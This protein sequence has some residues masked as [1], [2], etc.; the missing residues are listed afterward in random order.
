M[1]H[2]KT[3]INITP[4]DQAAKDILIA[5]LSQIGF[6]SFMETE[7]GIEAY[8]PSDKD[9][10][11]NE[12]TVPF[13]AWPEYTF[14]IRTETIEDK[15]WNEEWEKNYFKPIVIGNQCLVRS[16]FQKT[17]LTARY[18]ILID[19]RMAFGTGYHETTSLVLIHLL[20]MDVNNLRILDMGCGTAI[21]AILASMKGARDIVGIDNDPW[22][23]DN[24]RDNLQLNH[25]HNV[26]ILPG[27]ARLLDHYADTFDL[28]LTNINRN[29]LLEDMSSYQNVLKQDARIILSGFYSEDVP[30]I[31]KKA[32]SLNWEHILTKEQNN[33]IAVSY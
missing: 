11:V 29:I 13:L 28:V 12:E 21:L 19:P 18:E 8:M 10:T 17:D 4:P 2:S 24:A 5:Q 26:E 30:L 3:I 27:D 20:D 1:T 15:N 33:W 14:K 31:D 23:V 22:A 9:L 32:R 25:I 6:D 7:E 16:P